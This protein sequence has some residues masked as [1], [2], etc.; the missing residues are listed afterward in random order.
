MTLR[1]H[2]EVGDAYLALSQYYGPSDPDQRDRAFFK[3]LALYEQ[4]AQEKPDDSGIANAL[5]FQYARRARRYSQNESE[6]AEAT[7]RRALELHEQV[8]RTH[9]GRIDDWVGIYFVAKWYGE[10]LGI[11]GRPAEVEA[12]DRRTLAWFERPVVDLNWFDNAEYEREEPFVYFSEL[13][14][15]C[16]KPLK[17]IPVLKRARPHLVFDDQYAHYTAALT[18]LSL[19]LATDHDP[20]VRT[21]AVEL[22]RENVEFMSRTDAQTWLL[23][24]IALDQTGDLQGSDDAFKRGIELGAQKA[25]N[26][27]NNC[28]WQLASEPRF[29]IVRPIVAVRLAERAVKLL[30]D[31]AV[32][33]SAW[34]TLGVARYRAGDWKAAIAALEKAE[35][36]APDKYL[37]FN[38]FF[39]AMAHW[40][41]GDKPQARSWYDKAVPW[42]EKSQP[43]NEELIRFRAEA[44]ALLG[45]KNKKD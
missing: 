42:M 31:T 16:G 29:R 26:T 23:L 3:A 41:L 18:N 7:F 11:L 39:L 13:L 36:L 20:A 45:Q 6:K 17:A 19:K 33:A 8:A 43:K 35:S 10:L 5:A 2:F 38:A 40:Q 25:D 1:S 15:R 14:V 21:R 44:A 34:N 22:A 27:L 37:A 4:R 9:P 24:G 32:A 30:P 12:L 28:A